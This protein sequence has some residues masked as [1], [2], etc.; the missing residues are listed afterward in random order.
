M[1]DAPIGFPCST[2][3]ATKKHPLGKPLA[4]P[5]T[6]RRRAASG[7]PQLTIEQ[8]ASEEERIREASRRA[9][10]RLT[11]AETVPDGHLS[12]SQEAS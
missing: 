6:A 5:H 10:A 3:K 8:R 2:G 1:I 11:A 12:S 9:L 7:E 4:C